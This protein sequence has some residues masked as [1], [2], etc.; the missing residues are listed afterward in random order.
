VRRL[1]LVCCV[2]LLLLATVACDPFGDDVAA[3][4]EGHDI[5][6]SAVTALANDPIFNRGGATNSASVLDGDAARGALSALIG[7]Q[8]TR[9]E[10]DRRGEAVDSDDRQAVAQNYGQQLASSKP[11][12]R[13]ILT[14]G[15]EE[16]QALSRVLK[17]IDP[18]SKTER[19]NLW[20][21]TPSF[22]DVRCFDGIVAPVDGEQAIEAALNGGASFANVVKLGVGGAQAGFGQVQEC[23][24]RKVRPNLPAD[25]LSLIFDSKPGSTSSVHAQGNQSEVVV[26][27]HAI[28]DRKLG[29]T[30]DGVGELLQSVQ[31][32]G[33]DT[34]LPLVLVDADVHVNPQ[35]G[36]GFSPSAGV[37]P[38]VTP[39][40]TGAKLIAPSQPAA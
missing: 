17:G 25:V 39:P 4:V 31:Q 6:V 20:E 8:L 19:R 11:A 15:L 7:F 2:A 3:T 30:D 36:R 34:W 9:N 22:H 24:S 37:I 21:R 32:G 14:Q 16:Q 40:A 12:V 1:P 28:A 23:Y 27:V 18:S 10:L 33:T 5:P 35:Y 38:P 13:Q 29:P 26:F